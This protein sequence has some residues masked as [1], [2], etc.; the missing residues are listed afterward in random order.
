MAANQWGSEEAGA[1]AGLLGSSKKMRGS[2]V[3]CRVFE[4]KIVVVDRCKS[5]AIGWS[6]SNHTSEHGD[7]AVEGVN[8]RMK[9]V[10]V[11]L[12]QEG[13]GE[14]PSVTSACKRRGNVSGE[15]SK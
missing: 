7:A 11:L 2:G 5:V 3:G 10:G 9:N 15:G 14:V 1:A 4:S 8:V 6:L 12:K 13:E